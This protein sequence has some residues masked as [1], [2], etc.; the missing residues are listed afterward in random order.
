MESALNVAAHYR[1]EDVGLRPTWHAEHPS[2]T[3]PLKAQAKYLL[4]SLLGAMMAGTA[5]YCW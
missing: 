3:A 1:E 2:V 5:S 4:L